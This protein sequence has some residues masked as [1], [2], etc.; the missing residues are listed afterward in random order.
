MQ[1][2]SSYFDRGWIVSDFVDLM[3]FKSHKSGT[4]PNGDNQP[5]DILFNSSIKDLETQKLDINW[6]ANVHNVP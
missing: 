4:Y 6:P 1:K 5:S 3:N 2:G